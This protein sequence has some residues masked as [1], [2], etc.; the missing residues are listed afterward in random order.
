MK[1]EC[2]SLEEAVDFAAFS[3]GCKT[4]RQQMAEKVSS[5]EGVV[6]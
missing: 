3:G 5:G 2:M 4:V 1:F 6:C